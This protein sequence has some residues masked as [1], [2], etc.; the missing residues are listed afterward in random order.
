MKRRV[1]FNRTVLWGCCRRNRSPTGTQAECGDHGVPS[2]REGGRSRS[3]WSRPCR[4]AVEGAADARAPAKH[5]TRA[6]AAGKKTPL[7]N[8]GAELA[9]VAGRELT[10]HYEE[11][12]A[13]SL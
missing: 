7:A 1:R 11:L 6:G 5:R 13:Q 10:A 2:E 4:E 8:G 12:R 3:Q 9:G